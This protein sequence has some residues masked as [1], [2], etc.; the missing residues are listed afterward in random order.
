MRKAPPITN[1]TYLDH[2]FAPVTD[3]VTLTDLPV[4]GTLPPHL[5]GRYL[6]N[7]PNPVQPPAPGSYHWFLGDGMVHGLRL[8]DGRAEWYRNR[9]V[10]SSGVAEALG[11]EVRVGPVHAGMDFAPNTNIIGHA[12]RTFALVEAGALPYEL[13]DTLDTVGSCDFDGTLDG[14]FSAHPHRD[15]VTGE[16]HTVS[17]YWGWGNRL[18]YTVL[19]P[20][21]HIR[22]QIDIDVT[23]S[24]MV[25]D[26][27]LTARHVVVYDLPVTFDM[28]VVVGYADGPTGFP[29][30]WNADY[31]ARVGVL[32]RTGDSSKVTWCEVDPCYVFHALNA[33]DDGNDVVVDV[34][35]HPR[36]FAADRHG[37]NEGASVL[38]RWRIDPSA[39]RVHTEVIHERSQEFPRIDERLTGQRHRFGYTVGFAIASDDVDTAQ[40][41]VFRHDLETGK[42]TERELPAGTSMGEVVFVANGEDAAED[43]GVLMGF[44]HDAVTDRS[45]LRLFDAATLDDIATVHLPVRIPHGFHGNWIPS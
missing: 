38:E 30:A 28:D 4:T 12:G 13:T 15:P 17:Y 26:F 8:R 23:G 1:P 36:M 44:S 19:D 40:A 14:G 11:E 34:V 32:P 21:A 5:D 20:R 24:P 42:T 43:D 3:E 10:R 9:W 45:A 31:P 39:G 41:A 29:Y 7:G 22:R 18:R 16:L 27:S 37:P 33:Y 35:R 2:N 25:H 6:R